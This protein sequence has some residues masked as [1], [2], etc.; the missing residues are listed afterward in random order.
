MK[1]CTKCKVEKPKSEFQ[2]HPSCKDGI[3]S[4]CKG[5]CREIN[6][7]R[8]LEKKDSIIKVNNAWRNTN[9]EKVRAYNMLEKT[10]LARK[11]YANS[12]K[13][14]IRSRNRDYY[15]KNKEF[16]N[17]K[18]RE[19]AKNN[20]ERLYL[21]SRIWVT[22][23]KEQNQKHKNDW[24]KRNHDKACFY[25][26][27]RRAKKLQATPP[28]DNELNDFLI[29]EIYSLSALRTKTLGIQFHVDH[30]VPLISPVVCGLHIAANLQ[31]ITASENQIKSNLSWPDMP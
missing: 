19:Y 5:C 20:K 25:S 10:I 23:N 26:A 2:K 31:I 24:F 18:N 13:D 8:Y 27:N 6:A 22:A 9:K 16:I 11:V 7:I 28:W 15:L 21:A 14:I 3:K 29:E 1:I 30:I 12:S 4:R 17:I